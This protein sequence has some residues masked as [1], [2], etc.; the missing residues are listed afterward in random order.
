MSY[1]TS[2]SVVGNSGASTA[3]LVGWLNLIYALHALS[4]VTGIVGAATVVGA[5]LLGWPSI[6]AVLITYMKRG[7]A[8][9]TW[10]DSHFRWQLRT[11]WYGV[12]WVA[13]S[14]LSLL[15]TL[16]MAIVVVWMPL[17]VL[18]VW[19]IYRVGRGWSALSARQPMY[20]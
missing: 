20:V 14:G 18:T 8:R 5:F 19:F 12:L 17:A 2:S 15:F 6:I 1:S 4:I 16:G 9:G 3:S 7:E 13:L 10:L 11:F